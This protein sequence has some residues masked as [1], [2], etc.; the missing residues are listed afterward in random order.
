MLVNL[1]LLCQELV[2][3]CVRHKQVLVEVVWALELDFLEQCF[4]V[5]LLKL[6]NAFGRSRSHHTPAKSSFEFAT[7][8]W[9][10]RPV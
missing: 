10:H 3:E 9:G 5:P 2:K 8:V 4:V 7:T 6:I 1:W